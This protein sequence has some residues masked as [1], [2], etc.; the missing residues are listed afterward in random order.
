MD[1]YLSMHRRYFFPSRRP[2]YWWNSELSRLRSVC[3]VVRRVGQR[4][5]GR[6][7]QEVRESI[8]NNARRNHKLSIEQ[9][10]RT[11]S[12]SF[13]WKRIQS[14]GFVLGPLLPIRKKSLH[15]RQKKHGHQQ[16]NS[17]CQ[18]GE[19]YHH[20]KIINQMPCSNNRYEV[21]LQVAF[22]HVSMVLVKCGP[23]IHR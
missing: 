3:Y 4:A 11:A 6:V 23:A 20:F 17:S 19:P 5:I 1:C 12:S 8:F 16:K 15:S 7:N 9:S 10:K 18:N 22:I 2:N 13:A 21:E 14:K